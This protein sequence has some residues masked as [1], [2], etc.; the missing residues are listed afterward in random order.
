MLLANILLSFV[1]IFKTKALECISVVN[2]KC[3]ARPKIIQTNSNEPVFYPLS[4]QYFYPLINAEKIVIPLMIQWQ[5]YAYQI[6]L[7]T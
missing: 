4:I 7:K 6:L 2:Q 3:M 5:N 1:N